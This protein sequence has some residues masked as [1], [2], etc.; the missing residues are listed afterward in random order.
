M[1]ISHYLCTSLS[2]HKRK[3]T[4]S[5]DM[6][7]VTTRGVLPHT[8]ANHMVFLLCHDFIK[9]MYINIILMKTRLHFF[10]ITC[11]NVT[12]ILYITCYNVNYFVSQPMRLD[13]TGGSGFC[14]WV[15]ILPVGLDIKT[16]WTRLLLYHVIY[17]Q[18]WHNEAYP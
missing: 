5:G 6:A 2:G 15:W 11:Y 9:F 16:P 14:Q 17:T 3:P 10:Y 18:P 7:G 8:P 4:V 13:F 1:R 12:L